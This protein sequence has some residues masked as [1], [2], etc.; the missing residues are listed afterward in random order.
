[1]TW[2]TEISSSLRPFQLVVHLS[3][4]L[5][6]TQE[7]LPHLGSLWPDA[8]PHTHSHSDS[9]SSLASICSSTHIL[10][11]SLW[12][13]AH[14]FK[15]FESYQCCAGRGGHQLQPSAALRTFMKNFQKQDLPRFAQKN[16]RRQM[17]RRHAVFFLCYLYWQ[18][19]YNYE[20]PELGMYNLSIRSIYIWD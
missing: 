18:S 11:A 6:Q 4:F 9:H 12:G 14:I 20:K 5:E 2:V 15:V 17:C 19:C 16:L 8:M 1:M 13:N 3:A 7:F 10:L